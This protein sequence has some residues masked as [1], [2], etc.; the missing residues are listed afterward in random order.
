MVTQSIIR[1]PFTTERSRDWFVKWRDITHRCNMGSL[2]LN[3]DDVNDKL[4]I[5]LH[6]MRLLELTPDQFSHLDASQIIN[7][8]AIASE[9]RSKKDDS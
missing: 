7:L 4:T 3:M 9:L 2:V 8:L 6:G 1:P 5:T